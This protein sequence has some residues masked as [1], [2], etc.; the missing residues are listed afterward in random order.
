M[1]SKVFLKRNNWSTLI[2][3]VAAAVLVCACMQKQSVQVSP[4]T[5]TLPLPEEE[6]TEK[7]AGEDPRLSAARELTR[8]GQ[9][10]LRSGDPDAAIRVLERAV[11]LSPFSPQNYY[12]L[13]EAW[14]L[15]E[16][17]RQAAEFNRLAE[18]YLEQDPDWNERIA[19]Q[20]E[21]ITGFR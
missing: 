4:E 16:S 5:T 18:T 15:K 6:S 20:R 1:A 19:R 17:P 8:R 7:D 14:I 10:Y 2:F 12:Y 9:V 13:S 3:L 11:N 21:R